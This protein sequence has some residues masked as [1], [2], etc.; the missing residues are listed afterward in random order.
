MAV[1]F[2]IKSANKLSS[3]NFDKENKTVSRKKKE[4]NI[5]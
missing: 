3:C 5:S 2:K 4:H 1:R